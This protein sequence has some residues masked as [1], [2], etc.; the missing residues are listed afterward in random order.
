MRIFSLFLLLSFALVSCDE[1]FDITREWKDVPIVYA[2][3][4]PQDSIH[5]VRLEKAFLDPKKNALEMALEPDSLYYKNATVA[6]LDLSDGRTYQLT[7]I[8][9]N[10][11][12]KPREEGPFAQAPNVLFAISNDVLRVEPGRSYRLIIERG[13][14]KP[15]ITSTT[16]VVPTFSIFQPRPDLNTRIL[17]N[18]IIRITWDQKPEIP[19]F[20][21]WMDF[22]YIEVPKGQ[23]AP[24]TRKKLSWQVGSRVT[25]DRV[26]FNGELFHRML[27][28]RI[29]VDPSVDR[30][31]SDVTFRVV[32]A[33][34]E[35]Y[36]YIK[37]FIA[38][39][40]ITGTQE[41]P[42]YTNLSDGFG[43]FS[44]RSR[45]RNGNIRLDPVTI[46]LIRDSEL[47]KDLGFK[48]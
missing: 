16:Q 22:E 34:Q 13:D 1:D 43:I 8:D 39:S 4:S 40:G 14:G 45:M 26:S 19:V 35:L 21:V 37:V 12:G 36:D 29:K 28:D 27:A 41:I 44:S 32:G 38:N 48:G 33:G 11:E 20:D 9:G 23:S 46:E 18:S 47:T 42:K 30:Y 25:S 24:Q 15:Q 2:I 3:L 17:Y 31:A 6:I 7:R 5:Y 10:E